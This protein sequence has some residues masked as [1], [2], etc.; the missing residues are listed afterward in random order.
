MSLALRSHPQQTRCG[1]E[2]R[3]CRALHVSAAS[4][5]ICRSTIT[6]SGRR[7]PA[8]SLEP[9]IKT[10]DKLQSRN[11]P[12][13]LWYPQGVIPSR[14]ALVGGSLTTIVAMTALASIIY[15]DPSLHHILYP[16]Y[17]LCIS[18]AFL[19]AS[20]AVAAGLYEPTWARIRIRLGKWKPKLSTV[21]HW[22]HVTAVE[23]PSLAQMVEDFTPPSFDRDSFPSIGGKP[24]WVKVGI[25][26]P[27]TPLPRLTPSRSM[28]TASFLQLLNDGPV[29]NLITTFRTEG[30]DR[31]WQPFQAPRRALQDAVLIS[32]NH[33]KVPIGWARLI[34]PD[35]RSPSP[36]TTSNYADL[37]LYISLPTHDD[38][39]SP[40]ADLTKWQERFDQVFDTV[41]AFMVCLAN[42]AILGSSG[43]PTTAAVSEM[44]PDLVAHV[45]I[46][47]GAPNS[48]TQ[49]VDVSNLSY[50]EGA[51]PSGTFAAY[52]VA[53]PIG[54]P[55]ATLAQAWLIQ[56]CDEALHL[57]DYELILP[58]VADWAENRPRLTELPPVNRRALLVSVGA[59][60]VTLTSIVVIGD[61]I[62]SGQI[63]KKY[64]Y[65]PPSPSPSPVP[66]SSPRPSGSGLSRPAT[67]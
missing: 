5:Y 25:H 13:R 53:D 6:T 26:V 63:V 48:I 55:P 45:G 64:L 51:H 57:S 62:T 21:D 14:K 41:K 23:V 34:L 58:S 1:P 29:T 8:G 52:A 42:D 16:F 38:N 19:S 9:A 61:N 31:S 3:T 46:S 37:I 67:S 15:I 49:L 24:G 10:E 65:P 33:E 27:S 20:V 56:M 59:A 7:Q 66:S 43:T 30:S 18:T 36:S 22:R 39:E 17:W 28:V 2:S 50:V 4:G 54:E 32:G 60:A 35:S 44:V 40:P 11:L 47:L 12:S